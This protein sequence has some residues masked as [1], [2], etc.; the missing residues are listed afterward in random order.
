[1]TEENNEKTEKKQPLAKFQVGAVAATIWEN[2]VKVEGK[3]KAMH[4]ITIE[5]SYTKDDGA[6]WDKTSSFGPRD[7]QAVEVVAREAYKYLFMK[8]HPGVDN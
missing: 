7:L 1:M 4:S 3:D 2:V 6:N 8:Q 5:R